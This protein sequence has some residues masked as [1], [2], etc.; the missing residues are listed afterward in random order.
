[1][2]VIVPYP[3]NYSI[4]H[5]CCSCAAE[6][7]EYRFQAK[8]K[9]NQGVNVKASVNMTFFQCKSC[10]D[11]LVTL[12]KNRKPFWRS[13]PDDITRKR[14]D[15]LKLPVKIL[16][17]S[18]EEGWFGNIKGGAIKLDFVNNNYGM[19]F[20]MINKG[21]S[22]SVYCS[23]CG[24]EVVESGIVLGKAT[25][26]GSVCLDCKKLYC[27]DCLKTG[28][29]NKPCPECGE[30]TENADISTLIQIGILE[31]K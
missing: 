26:I 30:I 31:I 9:V 2:K 6:D 8:S 25:W 7:P 4:P 20:M 11:E 24:N 14:I 12:L 23:N 27:N 21:L 13:D 19:M 5:R 10:R 16:D 15:L 22:A 29:K 3:G 18:F 17:F 1:M 28:W